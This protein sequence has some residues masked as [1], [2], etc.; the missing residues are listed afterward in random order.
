[1]NIF[2]ISLQPQACAEA[3]D[4]KRLNKMI[5]ETAQIFCTAVGGKYKPTHENHPVVLWVK[6]SRSN[7]NWAFA[8]GLFACEEWAKRFA[9]QHACLAVIEDCRKRLHT[10]PDTRKDQSLES[11]E[12]MFP[13][14]F[15]NC[16]AFPD[17]EDVTVAYKMTLNDKWDKDVYRPVWSNRK[18][19]AWARWKSTRQDFS[20]THTVAF[21]YHYEQR[22]KRVRLDA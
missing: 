19:P 13:T 3:L 7:G 12:P 8:F 20:R 14:S 22:N 11:K 2:V 17:A 4:D 15:C 18:P 10:L 9:K 21:K 5:V 1:M 6:S 16:S